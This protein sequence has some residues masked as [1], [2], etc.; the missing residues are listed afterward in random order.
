MATSHVEA[1]C[2]TVYETL[3]NIADILDVQKDVLI[4]SESLAICS[5]VGSCSVSK[6][7]DNFSPEH[8]KKW[9][10][11]LENDLIIDISI[12]EPDTHKRLTNQDQSEVKHIFDIIK[13][14]EIDVIDIR[15]TIKKEFLKANIKDIIHIPSI[16][17]LFFFERNLVESLTFKG[18]QNMQKQG[19]FLPDQS[20][21]IAV[22]TEVGILQSPLLTVFGLS[23][24]SS[25]E[26]FSHLLKMEPA[27]RA[28]HKARSLRDSTTIW[29]APL[30]EIA[31]VT[32][33]VTPIYAGLKATYEAML[34]V[35]NVLSLLQFCV[36]IHLGDA[37]NW[38]VSITHPGGPVFDID[39][40]TLYQDSS[41]SGLASPWYR[42]YK[43]AFLAESYDKI[44]IVRELIQREIHDKKSNPLPQLMELGPILLEGARAN[45][46]ILRHQA[47]EAYLRSRQEAI[48][49]VQTF[50][51]SIR[52]DLDALRK[53]VL[54]TTLRFS[55]GIIA[56]LAANVLK[57]ELSR[58]VI[59]VGFG[60]GLFYLVLAA[61]FQLLPLWQQYNIQLREAKQIVETHN[62][63]SLAERKRFI[64]Q[65]PKRNWNSSFTK[66]FLACSF[67]Y[68]L[69]AIA[70][71]AILIYLLNIAK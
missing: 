43:W 71:V 34:G 37:K 48:E 54:D 65:L 31:P 11:V 33:Q 52:K 68:M 59:A 21:T 50:V 25:I 56:F 22:L 63:L 7:T 14:Y 4:K 1:F 27:I 58:I 51:I 62:E 66:W 15:V 67:V 30:A 18:I 29:A 61:I 32:F 28:W 26:K 19:V 24:S 39:C 47:F 49:A 41:T 53:D 17:A 23:N 5:F 9:Y 20:T 6:F 35:S 70:L 16:D 13:R 57:L 36:S 45:Y 2:S 44:D 42:L 46:K 8:L 64:D 40:D 38:H 12:D 10:S 55:A 3:K 69:W 60:L